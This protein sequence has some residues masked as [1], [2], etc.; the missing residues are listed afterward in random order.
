MTGEHWPAGGGEG[1][2]GA[3]DSVAQVRAI[4][5]LHH[6]RGLELDRPAEAVEEALSRAEEDGAPRAPRSHVVGEHE[7]RDAV[8]VVGS[9]SVR[10]MPR[11]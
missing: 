3:H 7:D 6:P 9:K 8:V 5:P 1:S 10:V 4:A 11:G 2:G